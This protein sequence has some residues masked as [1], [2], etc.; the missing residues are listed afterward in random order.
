MGII[1]IRING[2]KES[3]IYHKYFQDT[4]KITQECCEKFPFGFFLF[5]VS[6]T[7]FN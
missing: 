7:K 1:F 2:I 3:A 4:F 6:E 5:F